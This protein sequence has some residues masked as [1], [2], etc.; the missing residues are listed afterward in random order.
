MEH[1]EWSKKLCLQLPVLLGLDIFAVQPYFVTGGIASRLNA[2]VVGSL[3]MFL[4]MVEVLS[5]N[6]YQ[7]S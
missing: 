3:L 5:A 1:P 7:L 6:K 2:F 4:G